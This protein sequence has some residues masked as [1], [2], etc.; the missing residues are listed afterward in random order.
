MD[1]LNKPNFDISEPT[2]E[3]I[4]KTIQKIQD[5][6]DITLSNDDA[7]AY[8]K[9]YEELK[10]WFLI[11]KNLQSSDSIAEEV[12]E[13]MQGMIEES[14][15]LEVSEYEVRTISDES[16]DTVVAREKERIGKELKTIIA[17]YKK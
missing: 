17:K 11:E 14:H 2:D 4:K 12:A 9:L 1:E 10:L 6:H 3:E 7:I 8:T 13:K 5:Q 16:L 15:G